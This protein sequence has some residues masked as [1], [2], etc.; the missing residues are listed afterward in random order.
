MGRTKT[1]AIQQ[2]H[3]LLVEGK[4]DIVFF[5]PFIQHLNLSIQ[6]IQAEGNAGFGGTLDALRRLSEYDTV[7][8]IG[9]VRDADDDP[10]Q[11][12]QDVCEKIRKEGFPLPPAILKPTNTRPAISILIVPPDKEGTGRML[13]DLLFEAVKSDPAGVCI[14]EYFQCLHESKIVTNPKQVAKVKVNAFLATRYNP[15]DPLTKI[16]ATQY[17]NFDSPIFNKV[18]TFLQ[19]IASQES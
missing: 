6:V 7:Q 16:V 17:W 8:A 4:E 10:E 15:A 19:Q 9:I 13:E 1:L 14:N 12:F 5:E 2:P 3:L 18:K 11:A